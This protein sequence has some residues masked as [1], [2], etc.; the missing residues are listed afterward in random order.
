M[1][2]PV[3]GTER[4]VAR[5]VNRQQSRAYSRSTSAKAALTRVPM[6]PRR[7]S[8]PSTV[9]RRATTTVPRIVRIP[10]ARSFQL[11][12]NGGSGGGGAALEYQPGRPG[13]YTRDI[14]VDVTEIQNGKGNGK[15]V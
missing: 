13:Q 4:A 5:A 3:S 8:I 10:K 14:A 12:P 9:N 7:C 6:P 2:L 11:P 15:G 1:A